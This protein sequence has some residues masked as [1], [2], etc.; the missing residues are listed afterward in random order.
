MV[1]GELNGKEH[2]PEPLH[3]LTEW[4]VLLNGP[5]R[6]VYWWNGG[7]FGGTGMIGWIFG[8]L[9]KSIASTL[10]LAGPKSSKVKNK[11]KPLDLGLF[12]PC[13]FSG[14]FSL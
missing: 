11:P 7:A 2:N 6:W 10:S 8:W 1:K 5:S 12:L 3:R 4:V 13:L 14:P 9:K